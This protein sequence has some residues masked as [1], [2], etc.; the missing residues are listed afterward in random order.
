MANGPDTDSRLLDL[1]CKKSVAMRRGDR[2]VAF[3]IPVTTFSSFQID[4][5]TQALLREIASAQPRPTVPS[6]WGRVLDLG[7]GYGPICV[8]L[9]AGGA[10]AQV[11][12]IDRDAL[13]VAYAERNASKNSLSDVSVSGGLAY[14]DLAGRQ[15]DAIV[16]NVPAKAGEPVHRMML[17]GAGR[18]L[19]EGGEVWIVVVR[20]L[21]PSIDKILS[22]DKIRL[23]RKVTRKEHAIYNYTF[24]GAIEPD[25]R[26]YVRGGSRFRWG[27][28]DYEMTSLFGLPEFDTLSRNTE[29]L[30][31]VIEGRLAGGRAGGLAV[32]NP[33]QGHIPV[34][35]CRLA[36][37]IREVSLL[38]RDLLSLRA[39][40]K[41]L[42]A[43]GFGGK[44]RTRHTV[45][46]RRQPAD[47]PP[48]LIAG[49]LNDKE[50][51]EIN[52]EKIGRAMA[53]YPGC[54]II[55]GCPAAFGFRLERALRKRG[56][57][58]SGKKKERGYCVLSYG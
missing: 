27:G 56:A 12:G 5:G 10:A 43:N 55:V 4:R 44:V 39:S 15:Y 16:S 28:R 20:P 34:L 3:D 51:I 14:D 40:M 45:T 22:H 26:A 21:E 30:L 46:F 31:R 49:V 29:L 50:G 25:P 23:L 47:E 18:H 7:C 54:T 38:S 11:D 13:A 41:N 37:T 42:A 24:L 36:G 52:C 53:D 57:R 58:S 6:G 2:R 1:Y 35:L 8:C 19:R 48:D 32:W 9:S 33:G 17:Q